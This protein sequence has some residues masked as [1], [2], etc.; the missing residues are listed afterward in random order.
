[1]NSTLKCF[2]GR[3][4]IGAV[5][6][7]FSVANRAETT[8]APPTAIPS[9]PAVRVFGRLPLA[10]EVNQGQA[11]PRVR[12][13]ARGPGYGVFLAADE[14]VL[15]LRD[16]GTA[17]GGE[18][19]S[20]L[21]RQ[22]KK[23]VWSQVVRMRFLGGTVTPDLFGLDNLPGHSNY[24]VG[25]D[26][27][28]WR[29][30]IPLYARVK[31]ENLYPGVDAI[32]HGSESR[33]EYDL[34]VAPGANPAVIRIGFQGTGRLR[35]DES[36]NLVL[37]VGTGEIVQHAPF[38]YQESGGAREILAG[39]FVLRGPREI[40]FAVSG[41]YDPARALVIDP[42]LSYSTYLGGTGIDEGHAIA[43]DASG[44]AYIV[45]TT[46]S[47]D[48]PVVN[49]RQGTARGARDV[50]V[51]K[52]DPSGSGLAY[53]TYLGGSGDDYGHGV[54][55]D[56]SGSAYVTGWTGSTNF[57]V[58][59]AFQA[60]KG[61]ATSDVDAFVAKLSPDG[62]TLVYST[63]LGG[64]AVDSGWAIAVDADGRAH[65]A[66][67][68]MSNNFPLANPLQS[69]HAN[70]GINAD[71]F[72]TR[73]SPDGSALSFS[74]YLGGSGDDRA[75]GLALDP[76]GNIYVA[77][78][79]T[80]PD[81]PMINAMN[82]TLRSTDAF[83]LK[84]DASRLAFVYSTFLGGSNREEGP[85]IAMAVDAA[86]DAFVT[87]HTNSTDFPLL[88]PVLPIPTN[89]SGDW[90]GF[91]TKIDPLG[92]ALA[93]STYL[94]GHGGNIPQGIAVDVAGQAHVIGSTWSADFPLVLP[95]DATIDSL[96]PD[97]FVTTLN[98]DGGA[99]VYSTYLGGS[100]T[101][102]G[103]AIAL[104]A[105][106]DAYVT[107]V[108]SS[109]NFPTVNPFQA[110]HAGSGSDAFVAKIL[111]DG[112]APSPAS[113]PSPAGSGGRF[114]QDDSGLAYSGSWFPNSHCSHSHGT[115]VLATD[116]GSSITV[117]FNGTSIRWIGYRD[118]W[119]G[120]ASIFLDGAFVQ[121]VDTYASAAQYQVLLFA[122][123]GLAT[124]THTLVVEATGTHGA[125]SGGSWI[126]VDAIDVIGT[127]F[128]PITDSDGDGV[129]DNLD[130]SPS[131]P[132]AWRTPSPAQSLQVSGGPADLVL[133]WQAPLD[134]GGMTTTYDVLRSANPAD[135]TTAECV[136]T[137][138]ATTSV[139][140]T[141][142]PGNEFYLVRS[143]NACGGTL[144]TDSAGAE[145]AGAAC[146]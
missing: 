13:L 44:S 45:G 124:G 27:G 130:C 71:G 12:F 129:P 41:A 10:F 48:F 63:Y 93:Y 117:T 80:S 77:G 105:A 69:C 37:P 137:A 72:V 73:L 102:E 139:T 135:F 66:G 28:K 106:G 133:A 76:A 47:T 79:T 95:L 32:F 126:W 57:P 1:M 29:K 17:T 46:T 136:A 91:V 111:H 55:V 25:G 4:G 24:L 54:A 15:V 88:N 58:V 51:A 142:L 128:L 20:G 86:G 84:I 118:P 96:Y 131:D 19:K 123:A 122:A 127:I 59:G 40:G 92:S 9:S 113:N 103:M 39:K 89:P 61:G 120:I 18:A 109:Y 110:A 146:P 121:T 33:L 144:G 134:Q 43:V 98:A 145:R 85:A 132:T 52:L 90:Y 74:T 68:T 31:Y 38:I 64:S 6:L 141:P 21:S 97:T 78:D 99:F 70:F 138:I 114:E 16:A 116:P 50:F 101:Q 34:V 2:A 22:A 35:L 104:D 62:S 125:P 11:K 75:W 107:G 119:S 36:G 3:L 8:P 23:D 100:G 60:A 83:V 30:G 143:R 82:Q 81:F 140:V 115:A 5:L 65:V 112:P 42:V 56:G 26:P 94:G 108:T 49:P 67:I 7:L 14:A 53:S 87:G